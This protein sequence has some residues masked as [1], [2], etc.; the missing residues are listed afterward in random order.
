[1]MAMVNKTDELDVHGLNVLKRNGT[2]PTVWIPLAP[3]R[4]LR[5]L[6]RGRMA[7]SAHRTRLKNRIHAALSRRGLVAP[8]CSDLFGPRGREAL[9]KLIAQLPPAA[10]M[11]VRMHLGG[12]ELAE[13]QIAQIERRLANRL[14]ETDTI[15]LLQT[16]PGVGP[17]LGAVMALEIGQVERFP[18][19]EH[20]AAYA[21]TIPRV[22]TPA[23][24]RFGTVSCATT[25]TTPCAGPSSRR[26]MSFPSITYDFPTVT[27]AASI[28]GCVCTKVMRRRS[29]RWRGTWQKRPG[30]S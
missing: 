23:G 15:R 3:L 28:A 6:T 1:M 11:M 14:T 7:I 30:A 12:L 10:G 29:A 4:D 16:L 27:S 25:S 19:A 5:E 26:R 8:R 13:D 22:H 17:I 24:T 9:A 20:L 21:G 2:L 18:S